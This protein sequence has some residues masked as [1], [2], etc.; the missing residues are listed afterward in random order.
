MIMI[1]IAIVDDA[2]IICQTIE[3]FLI[4]FSKK[5]GVSVDYDS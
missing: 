1:R 5:N 3:E 2:D 4:S